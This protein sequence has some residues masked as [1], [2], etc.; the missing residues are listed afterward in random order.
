[1]G[2]VIGLDFGNA[3]SYTVF[4]SGIDE[5]TRRGGNVK[6]L[7]NNQLHNNGIPSMFHIDGRGRKTY[8]IDAARGR[9][10]KNRRDMLKSKIGTTETI[11]GHTISYD[12]EIVHLIKYIVDSAND[13]LQQQTGET[14]DTVSIAYPV[15]YSEGQA[16]R[17]VELAERVTLKN[18]K[19]L[20]VLGRI[21]ESEAAA[22]SYLS[23]AVL[24]AGERDFTVMV[25]DLGAGTFDASVVTAHQQ[26]NGAIS[27]YEVIRNDGATDC[28][29]K[30]FTDAMC[31]ILLRGYSE[32]GIQPPQNDAAQDR[33][34][35]DAEEIKI[36]LS[37]HDYQ[38]YVLDENRDVVAEFTA[39]QLERETESLVAETIEITKNLYRSVDTKPTKIVLVGGQSQMPIIKRRLAEAFPQIGEQNI[40]SHK[41]QQAIAEGAARFGVIQPERS[42]RNQP[43]NDPT[44]VLLRTLGMIGLGKVRIDPNNI[45]SGWKISELVPYNSQLPFTSTEFPF[46]NIDPATRH[47]V[48]FYQAKCEHPD[49][50]ETSDG[51]YP[52]FNKIVSLII[53]FQVDQP[54]IFD[55]LVS[56]EFDARGNMLFKVRDPLGRF[57]PVVSQQINF[58]EVR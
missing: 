2:H 39:K 31:R 35:R 41:P 49:L 22:L 19:R 32:S 10:E 33:L 56:V 53:D 47:E 1:M 8:G 40:L 38:E 57:S 4:I 17:L 14:T 23:E 29:G 50:I 11:A 43:A 48:T 6:W 34:R 16:N 5:N 37:S 3:N 15:K 28:G 9:P 18:G 42:S 27:R 36:Y 20:R 25:F 58:T 52:D 12:D 51:E 55:F 54:G 44:P 30:R 45:N 7:V 26:R 46:R 21:K 13:I 24:G